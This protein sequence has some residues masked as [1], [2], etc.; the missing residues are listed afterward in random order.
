MS[1]IRT[2]AASDW[3]RLVGLRRFLLLAIMAGTFG[4]GLELLFIGHAEDP[5]QLVP[6]VLLPAGLIVLAWH[7]V[8]P[9]RASV[10]TVRLLMALFVA[11]GVLG[12]GLHYQGNREFELE[13]YPAMAGMELVRETL[14]GATPVLAPG[15]MALLGLV[16]LAAVYRFSSGPQNGSGITEE[17]AS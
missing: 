6:I 12:V 15:S 10:R 1:R 14:T 7:A 8:G 9:S 4:M 13:M 2:G 11:S 5:L 3:E 17:D 16:G